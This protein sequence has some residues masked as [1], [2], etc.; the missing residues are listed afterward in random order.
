MGSDMA[1]DG[2]ITKEEITS[3]KRSEQRYRDLQPLRKD[4]YAASARYFKD[5]REK[6]SKIRA[7]L[8]KD[9]EYSNYSLII[10]TYQEFTVST[11]H[12]RLRKI[13]EM[14]VM[15][16]SGATVSIDMMTDEERRFFE[17]VKHSTAAVYN[18]FK[19]AAGDESIVTTQHD[20]EEYGEPVEEPVKVARR[21]EPVRAAPV[22]KPEPAPVASVPETAEPPAEIFDPAEE[23]M[24]FPDDPDLFEEEEMQDFPDDIPVELMEPGTKKPAQ[25]AA[26]MILIRTIMDVPEFEM[27]RVYKF[28]KGEMAYLNKGIAQNLINVGMAVRVEP[29]S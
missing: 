14:A 22:R 26:D 6:R 19:R 24:Q 17:S 16:A 13:A 27:D 5:C 25:P 12:E 21:P 23:A 8:S 20:I 3:A 2:E 4:F 29:S 15:S 28:R 10:N 1:K 7:D 9:M 11:I 18:D